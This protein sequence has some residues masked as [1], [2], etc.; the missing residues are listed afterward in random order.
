MWGERDKQLEER[1][2]ET[3]MNK[4]KMQFRKVGGNEQK[5]GCAGQY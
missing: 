1:K 3:K 2:K 4:K 5:G